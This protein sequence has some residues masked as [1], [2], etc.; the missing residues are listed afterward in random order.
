MLKS[1]AKLGVI[2]AQAIPD[3]TYDVLGIIQSKVKN[4][5]CNPL[6]TLKGYTEKL[7]VHPTKLTNDCKT[8]GQAPDFTYIWRIPQKVEGLKVNINS[9][10]VTLVYPDTTTTPPPAPPVVNEPW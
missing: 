8:E 1:K 5:Y 9:G 4:G 2:S 6:L 7:Y 10:S 3:G